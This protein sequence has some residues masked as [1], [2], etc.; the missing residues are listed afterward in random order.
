MAT[1]GRRK[2]A[3]IK[4]LK[5]SAD[6]SFAEFGCMSVNLI[7]SPIQIQPVATQGFE[8]PILGVPI[9]REGFITE[10]GLLLHSSQSTTTSR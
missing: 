10:T 9:M 5:K 7:T 8:P 4:A 2:I 1:M 3:G 6:K